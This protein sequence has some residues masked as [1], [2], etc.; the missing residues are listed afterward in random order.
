LGLALSL[1]LPILNANARGIAEAQAAREAVR[2]AYEAELLAAV[3]TAAESRTRWNAAQARLE[4]L[5]AT[6]APLA[7]RQ[8][9]ETRRLLGVG[10]IN[11][12]LLMEALNTSYEAKT[13]SVEASKQAA[14]AFVALSALA[15]SPKGIQRLTKEISR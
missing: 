14:L 4:F 3:G 8:M 1:P 2:C 15:P 13:S 12:L 10:E 11:A 7:D 6:V 9:N 5:K